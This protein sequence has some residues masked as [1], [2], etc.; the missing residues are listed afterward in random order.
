MILDTVTGTD[1]NTYYKV[2]SDMALKD[3][4]SARNVEDQFKPSRDYVYACASDIQVVLEG[5]GKNTNIPDPEELS[6]HVIKGHVYETSFAWS[7]D[8]KTCK[9][10]FSCDECGTAVTKDCKITS[11]EVS[12]GMEYTASCEYEGATYTDSKVKEMLPFTDIETTDWF[13]KY[14]EWAYKENV[15][16]GYMESDGTRTF[17]PDNTCTRAENVTFLYNLL[18]ESDAAEGTDNPFTDVESDD[19]YYEFITWASENGYAS[20]YEES[21]GTYTFRPSK[22]CTR[23]EIITFIY[24]V[25][26]GKPVS[27]ADNPFTDIESD[28]WYYDFVR[29]GYQNDI[30]SGYEETNGSYSFRPDQ[31]CSRAEVATMLYRAFA[32]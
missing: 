5:S 29:W 16:V 13:Y 19:W 27:G 24:N 1:G 17:K 22:E 26:G 23:A 14:V 31:K 9:V 7:D 2:I 8:C 28:D 30:I 3:D 25:K 18:A 20:G 21:D 15:T 10:T 12:D 6:E 4:R 32:E 11:K